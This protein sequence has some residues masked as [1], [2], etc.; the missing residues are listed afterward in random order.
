[1][2]DNGAGDIRHNGLG[3][4]C[5]LHCDTVHRVGKHGRGGVGAIGHWVPNDGMTS[6]C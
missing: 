5:G 4:E 3:M 1:M 6:W 2:V